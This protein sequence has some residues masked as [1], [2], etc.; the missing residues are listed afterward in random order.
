MLESPTDQLGFLD[1]AARGIRGE[2]H[3]AD[4]KRKE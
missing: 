4:D 2:G 3:D 1:I